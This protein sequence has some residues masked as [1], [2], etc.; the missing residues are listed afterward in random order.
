MHIGLRLLI[1]KLG[2]IYT[3]FNW[4]RNMADSQEVYV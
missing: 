2:N 1:G 3:S 4:L